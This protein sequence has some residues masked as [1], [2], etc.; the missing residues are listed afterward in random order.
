MSITLWNWEFWPSDE[1]NERPDDMPFGG[2]EEQ[3][4]AGF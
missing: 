1:M 3:Q 4:D 2:E